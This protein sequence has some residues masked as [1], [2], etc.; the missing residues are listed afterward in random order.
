MANINRDK[1]ESLHFKSLS[2]IECP[3]CSRLIIPRVV[4]YY[5]AV[6]KTVC[7]FCVSS[8]WKAKKSWIDKCI[9]RV[10]FTFGFLILSMLFF[11]FVVDFINRF[12]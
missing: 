7:P 11:V 12:N 10:A 2:R 3:E 8:I 4:Y 6:V 9:E 1:A 5:G